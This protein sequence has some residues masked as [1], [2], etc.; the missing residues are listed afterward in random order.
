MKSLQRNLA[1]FIPLVL[2]TLLSGC[3]M[4]RG[5]F[6]AGLWL[7]VIIIGALVLLGFGLSRATRPR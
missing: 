7:G 1:P 6:K 2:A 3:A 5:V 4:V